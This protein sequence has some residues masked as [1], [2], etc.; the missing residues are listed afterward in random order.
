MRANCQQNIFLPLHQ[1]QRRI[2]STTA[3][4]FRWVDILLHVERIRKLETRPHVTNT[5]LQQ[6]FQYC[7]GR[8]L[9]LVHQTKIPFPSS[10]E[11]I[12]VAAYL[13]PQLNWNFS[14]IFSLLLRSSCVL[15]YIQFHFVDFSLFRFLFPFSAKRAYN[16]ITSNDT[17][18]FGGPHNLT[19]EGKWWRWRG[20]R[21]EQETHV[22]DQFI[23][24]IPLHFF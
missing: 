2:R 24:F 12:A 4:E 1:V 10:I 14:Y 11:K 15:F 16:S 6:C 7:I 23:V 9:N 8:N 21:P 17:T 5:T 22:H 19:L 3:S 13:F 20:K 18:F